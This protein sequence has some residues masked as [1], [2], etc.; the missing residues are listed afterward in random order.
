MKYFCYSSFTFVKINQI[1]VNAYFSV[2]LTLKFLA[3]TIFKILK[4]CL[5]M[6]FAY[7]YYIRRN[8]YIQYLK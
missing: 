1:M 7:K 8:F 3:P 5:N 2:V 4:C 6:V